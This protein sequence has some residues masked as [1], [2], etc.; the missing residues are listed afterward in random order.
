MQ[1]E[2]GIDSEFDGARRQNKVEDGND[3]NNGSRYSEAAAGW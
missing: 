1:A 3:V 2:Q